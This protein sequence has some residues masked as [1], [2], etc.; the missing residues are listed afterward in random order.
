MC[1]K[2]DTDY[3]GIAIV[4]VGIVVTILIGVWTRGWLF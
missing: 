1:N 3:I 2:S 4:I